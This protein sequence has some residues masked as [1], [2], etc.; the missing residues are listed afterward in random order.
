LSLTHLTVGNAA[1][2]CEAFL[3]KCPNVTVVDL[4]GCTLLA[5]STTLPRSIA[6]LPR[7]CR[8]VTEVCLVHHP[9]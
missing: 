5:R 1:A 3:P 9:F 8:H 6:A 7:F 4:E 2:F